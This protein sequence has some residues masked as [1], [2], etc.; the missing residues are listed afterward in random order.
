MITQVAE[1][2]WRGP[3]PTA[4]NFQELKKLG[5]KTILNLEDDM[6]AVEAERLRRP[7]NM[8]FIN[9][10][11]SEIKRPMVYDLRLV[12]TPYLADKSLHPIFVHC[13]HGQDRTGYVIAAYRMLA[14][15]WTFK[16]AYQECKDMGHAWYLYWYWQKSL[17]ELI[18]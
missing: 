5:V 11:M 3:R 10:P 18:K 1:G 4:C 15:G 14:Q 2:I 7:F 16:Q 17:K 9:V 8:R 6:E 13:K 12:T